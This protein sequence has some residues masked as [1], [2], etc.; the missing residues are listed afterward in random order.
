M[1]QRKEKK[2]RCTVLILKEQKVINDILRTW[3]TRWVN[4][5]KLLGQDSLDFVFLKLVS[6]LS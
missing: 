5:L 3:E 2:I 6:V 1:I 4:S